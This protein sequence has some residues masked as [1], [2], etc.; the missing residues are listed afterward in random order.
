MIVELLQNVPIEITGILVVG[1]FLIASLLVGNLVARLAPPQVREQHNELAGFILA[2]VGVIY[3]VLLAFVAIGVWERFEAA[4]ARTYDEATNLTIVYRDSG[5]FSNGEVLRAAIRDYVKH[6]IQNEWPRMQKGEHSVSARL[7]LE[8]VDR[9]VRNLDADTPQRVNVQARTLEAMDLALADR[10]A[11]ISEEATG[12]N[13]VMWVI[14]LIGAFVTVGFTF[15]FGF[16]QTIMQQ[17]MVG[18]LSILIGL[19][20]F[21]IVAL[22]YPFRGGLTVGPEAFE[23]AQRIFGIIGR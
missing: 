2:V 10:D 21:L 7:L 19:V 8:S 5:S 18:S 1:G 22:D 13:G 6:V 9:D 15:L 14:L 3:A 4:E 20:L 17:L 16:K 12:I 23:N 11:R